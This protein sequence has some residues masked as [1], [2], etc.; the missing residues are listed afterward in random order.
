MGSLGADPSV[1]DLQSGAVAD[2]LPAHKVPPRCALLRGVAGSLTFSFGVSLSG[3]W[4]L[5]NPEE[6]STDDRNRTGR[7]LQ[8]RDRRTC[9]L[10][11][12]KLRKRR[13]LS[14]AHT[15]MGG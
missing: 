10:S 9:R 13:D 12:R 4:K 14:P 15:W 11:V 8:R 3:L 1:P 7:L 6:G 5:L 2:L